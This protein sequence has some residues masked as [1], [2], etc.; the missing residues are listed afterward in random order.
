VTVNGYT[1]D[2]D[3]KEAMLVVSS[4]GDPDG[5]R[6]RVIANRTT[7]RPGGFVTLGDLELCMG[8]QR[9]A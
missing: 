4:L 2:E 8:G 7:A 5:E 1:Q 9:E 6:T 3:T